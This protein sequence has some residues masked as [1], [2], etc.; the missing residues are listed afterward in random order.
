VV[1]IAFYYVQRSPPV[2]ANREGIDMRPRR[3]YWLAA[4]ATVVLATTSL[5]ACSS[6]ATPKAS[7]GPTAKLTGDPVKLMLIVPLSGPSETFP[8]TVSA[9]KAAAQAINNAGGIKGRPVTILSCD[10]AFDPN[11]ATDC[12]RK[13]VA[14]HVLAIVGTQSAEGGSWFPVTSA[15]GIPAVGNWPNSSIESTSPLSFPFV[16]NTASLAGGT[17]IL[18]ANGAK[19][20]TAALPDITVSD[21]LKTLLNVGLKPFSQQVNNVIKMNVQATDYST[22]AAHLTGGGTDG[23]IIVGGGNQAKQMMTAIAQTGAQNIQKTVSTSALSPKDFKTLGSAAEGY[24]FVAQALPTTYVQDPGVAAMNA[25]LTALDPNL[26]QADTS[27]VDAWASVHV[28][29]TLAAKMATVD[30]ASLVSA[31]NGAGEISQPPLVPFD[32]AKPVSAGV[33]DF[34]RQVYIVQVKNGVEQPLFGAKPVD[35]TAIPST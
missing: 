26:A 4:I 19:H 5:A 6:K 21:Y 25:E 16:S 20:I 34:T 31:L 11:K 23:A 12:G 32:F 24:F 18:A 10:D 3:A 13:A 2:N 35:S 15:A 8:Q 1:P 29:A 7:S 27:A 22:Y 17:G 33:R 14:E 9:A 28:V 30:S